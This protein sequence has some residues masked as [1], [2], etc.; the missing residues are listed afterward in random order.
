M[1]I[2]ASNETGI[3]GDEPRTEDNV[4]EI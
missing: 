4:I 2:E 3:L 1:K